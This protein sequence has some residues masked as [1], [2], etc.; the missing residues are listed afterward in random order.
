V[1]EERLLAAAVEDERIPDLEADHGLAFT[2]LF[3]E[4]Q[5]DGL[6]VEGSR[7][8]GPDVDPLGIVP[9]GA[10]QPGVDLMVVHHHI[11]CLE[12][13]LT[14]HADQSGIAGAGADDEDAGAFLHG[15]L[16]Q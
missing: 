11:G 4:Q 10:E 1:Q 3:D 9:R 13:A 6:L 15:R 8:G 14:A 16:Y 5:R 12:L 2:R 7:R